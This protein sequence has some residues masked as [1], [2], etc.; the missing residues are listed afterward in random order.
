MYSNLAAALCKINKYDEALAAA[1]NATKVNPKWAKGYWRLGS[2]YE[3]KKDFLMAL[4]NYEKAVENDTEETTAVYKKAF[5]RML[6]R[7]GCEKK[8][9][10]EGCW[11]VQL[12]VSFATVYY[13]LLCPLRYSYEHI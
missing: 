12:P 7:L 9:G 13:L 10:E 6:D 2:I 3:L 11:S 1:K 8:E 4:N 5:K